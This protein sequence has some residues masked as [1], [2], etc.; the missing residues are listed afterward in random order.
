MSNVKQANQTKRLVQTALMVALVV[1]VSFVPFLGFVP[2][3][4]IKATTVHIPVILGAVL[5]GPKV[6]GLLGAVFGLCSIIKNTMEPAVVSFVFSPL[7]PVPGTDSGSWKALVIS[8][9]PRILVGVLAGLVY[10]GLSK[11]DKKGYLACGAAAA[12]GSAVNTIFV[13]GL[14]YWLFGPAYAAAKAI[15]FE[16]LLGAILTVV[17]T[18]GLA[19]MAVAIVLV[20]LVGRPLVHYLK[21][22]S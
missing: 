12:V 6:G 14:I 22:N 11:V 7:I 21:P 15:P 20:V 3:G 19:E 17:G 5:L 13:M 2:L 18:Q 9:V 10:Q 1:V 16:A 4:F 8:L